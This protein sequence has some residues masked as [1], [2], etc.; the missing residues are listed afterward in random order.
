MLPGCHV[1]LNFASPV[2]L[3]L[4]KLK[5]GNIIKAPKLIFCCSD[6]IHLK[7]YHTIYIKPRSTLNYRKIV[8]WKEKRVHKILI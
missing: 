3:Y 4:I 1:G 2:T 6:F 5:N 7:K 8:R